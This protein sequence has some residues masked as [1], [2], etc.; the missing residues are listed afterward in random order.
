M[1]IL[2]CPKPLIRL[3]VASFLLVYCGVDP[4]LSFLAGVLRYGTAG[5]LCER[6]WFLPP[7]FFPFFS[8]LWLV[9]FLRARVTPCG[10]SAVIA[11]AGEGIH[12]GRP[13]IPVAYGGRSHPR[14]ERHSVYCAPSGGPTLASR[15]GI[16]TASTAKCRSGE[17]TGPPEHDPRHPFSPNTTLCIFESFFWTLFSHPLPFF[18]IR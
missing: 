4:Q 8:G 15:G 6:V 3:T 11:T 9:P 13:A 10:S 17:C 2:V 5:S 14:V 1:R 7:F 16:S 12:E 18:T